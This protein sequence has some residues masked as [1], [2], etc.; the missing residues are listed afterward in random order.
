MNVLLN[1]VG[2]YYVHKTI[3]NSFVGGSTSY[4]CT[5]EQKQ[6]KGVAFIQEQYLRL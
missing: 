1:V 5:C 6:I 3:W 2:G 4:W